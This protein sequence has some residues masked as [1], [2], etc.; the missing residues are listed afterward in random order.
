MLASDSFTLPGLTIGGGEPPKGLLPGISRP[1]IPGTAGVACPKGDE[2]AGVI[3]GMTGAAGAAD[4]A[5]GAGAAAKGDGGGVPSG[6][7][8]SVGGDSGA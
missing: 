3:E 7:K 5:A 2:A 4:S 8:P 6:S 1:V